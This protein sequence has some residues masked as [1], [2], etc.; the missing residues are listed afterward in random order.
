MNSEE[1]RKAY[2]DAEQSRKEGYRQ[3]Y[4]K[5]IADAS[6]VL[7]QE[8]NDMFREF[9]SDAWQ[10]MCVVR[11]VLISFIDKEKGDEE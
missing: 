10:Y 4:A 1:R 11:S 2:M 6:E 9:S 5:A 3:G 7:E 8:Y